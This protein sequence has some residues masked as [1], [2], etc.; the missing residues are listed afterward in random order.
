LI[1]KVTVLND[2]LK[3]SEK[4]EFLVEITREKSKD[5]E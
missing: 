4:T 3:N 1:A 2:K 5:D